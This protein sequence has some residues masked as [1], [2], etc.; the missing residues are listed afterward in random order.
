MWTNNEDDD[1]KLKL[2]YDLIMWYKHWYMGDDQAL[3]NH[4]LLFEKHYDPRLFDN[5]KTRDE[6]IIKFMTFLQNELGKSEID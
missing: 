4:L 3:T 2:R 5:K 6:D 1:L